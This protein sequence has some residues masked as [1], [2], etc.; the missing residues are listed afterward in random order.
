MNVSALVNLLITVKVFKG[1]VVVGRLLL[2]LR[3]KI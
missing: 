1:K 2:F 3:V